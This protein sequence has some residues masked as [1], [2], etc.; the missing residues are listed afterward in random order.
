MSTGTLICPGCV[1]AQET[2]GKA[3]SSHFWLVLTPCESQTEGS[4]GIVYCLS[5]EGVPTMSTESCTK[6][7]KFIGY[8]HLKNSLLYLLAEQ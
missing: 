4:G 2:D 3:L 8:R 5:V 6:T 1:H 7:G